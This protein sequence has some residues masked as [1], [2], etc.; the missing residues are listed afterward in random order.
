MPDPTP[1]SCPAWTVRRP[2]RTL[3]LASARARYLTADRPAR[4]GR[5]SVLRF[6]P[7]Q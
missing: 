1:V 4:R 5:P 7:V 3:P 6:V 2:G